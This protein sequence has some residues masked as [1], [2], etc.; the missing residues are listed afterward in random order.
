MTASVFPSVPGFGNRRSGCR[1]RA[2]MPPVTL[3]Y[4]R[5]PAPAETGGPGHG[6]ARGRPVCQAGVR[7]VTVTSERSADA[8]TLS[9][10][11]SGSAAKSSAERSTTGVR[12]P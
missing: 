6:R 12:M 11:P 3:P 9:P 1:S 8:S 4:G 2:A 10:A 5:D 7:S